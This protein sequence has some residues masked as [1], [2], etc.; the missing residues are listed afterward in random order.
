MEKVMAKG[1]FTSEDITQI[2]RILSMMSIGNDQLPKHAEKMVK[3]RW[4]K[5]V[6]KAKI[7][8]IKNLSQSMI[9]ELTTAHD[10]LKSG[11][12]DDTRDE[13]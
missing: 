7:N 4:E 2:A 9:Q 6:A 10:A 8:A 3:H 11:R 13:A 1:N 12:G 5:E